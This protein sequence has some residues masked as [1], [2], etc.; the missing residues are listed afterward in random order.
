MSNGEPSASE[1]RTRTPSFKL[2]LAMVGLG[3]GPGLVIGVVLWATTGHLWAGV[4]AFAVVCLV[5]SIVLGAIAAN[6][7]RKQEVRSR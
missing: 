3:W 2:V 6:R 7:R 4:L 1:A 5:T